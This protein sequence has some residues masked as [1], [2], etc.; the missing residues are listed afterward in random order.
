MGYALLDNN[1]FHPICVVKPRCFFLG[2]L[3]RFGRLFGVGYSRITAVLR[4]RLNLRV[5][6]CFTGI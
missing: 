4:I 1:L 5:T 3:G 2:L 6:A